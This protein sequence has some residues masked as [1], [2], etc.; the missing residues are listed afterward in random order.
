MIS[1]PIN[2]LNGKYKECYDFLN[3]YLFSKID[4]DFFVAGGFIRRFLYKRNPF[5]S[6]IDL[7]FKNNNDLVKVYEYFTSIGFVNISENQ[8]S[9]KLKKNN[10]H[11]DLV[12][13]FFP[14]CIEVIQS[15]DFTICC[16]GFDRNAFY[17]H[18][19]FELHVERKA[20]RLNNS[21]NV[22][23]I[24]YRLQKYAKMGFGADPYQLAYIH[25]LIKNDKDNKNNKVLLQ[26]HSPQQ[27]VRTLGEYGYSVDIDF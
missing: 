1:T 7:Y 16:A 11:L 18:V 5:T 9:Y 14:S 22:P 15:F 2:K 23:S 10:I 17:K 19:S 25:Q 26:S 12:K 4:I 24:L 27:T 20:I 3:F 13:R 8:N 21:E 6:D